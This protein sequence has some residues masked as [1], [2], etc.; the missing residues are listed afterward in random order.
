MGTFANLYRESGAKIAKEKVEEFKKRL[1][2]LYQAGGMMELERV[3]L[4]GKTIGTIRKAAMHEYGMD[5]YY[6]YFEDDCWENAGFS[7]KSNHVWSG[8]IGWRQFHTAVVA[9]Y[10]LEELYTDG[11]AIA[12]VDADPVTAYAYTGWINYLFQEKFYFKNRDPWKLF[13]TMHKDEDNYYLAR[14]NWQDFIREEYGV[15]GYFEIYAVLNSTEA[16]VAHIEDLVGVSEEKVD[17]KERQENF[18][19]L[20][21]AKAAKKAI[22]KFK[23]TSPLTG[24]EAALFLVEML[25]KYYEQDSMALSIGDEYSDS[26]LRAIMLFTAISDVPAYVF[27]AI[28]ETFEMDFWELWGRFSGVARRR[29]SEER[30][31]YNHIVGEVTTMELFHQSPD[32]MIYYGELDGSIKFS[33]ELQNW[34][35][36]IKGQFDGLMKEDVQVANPLRWIVDLMVYADEEYY[37]IYTF[38]DF[39]EETMENL[40]DKKYLVLWKIY[41]DML[42]SPELEEAGSV[43]F[44]PEGSEYEREG[45]HYLGEQP[46]RRLITSWD[47]ME[48]DKRYNKARVML[49]RYMALVANKELREK[50]FGF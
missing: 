18:N 21:C 7:I 22:E 35:Q 49:R 24:E 30:E 20:N 31:E 50:V 5:F 28:A 4:F 11:T 29:I 33:E 3:S 6:N 43:I 47:I 44:V 46:R 45:L 34:F 9:A 15:L 17:K 12:M 25:R 2:V 1:E 14:M 16:A 10:V 37:R 23:E 38:S 32:D 42:H 8:K 39:F 40:M 41:D 13:K 36:K 27:K 48:K 19:F 26:V